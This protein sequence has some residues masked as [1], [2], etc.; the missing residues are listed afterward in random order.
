MANGM[1]LTTHQQTTMNRLLQRSLQQLHM[2]A[3]ELTHEISSVMNSNPLL[4]AVEDTNTA[5][6]H[7]AETAGE[8]PAPESDAD[9][10]PRTSAYENWGRTRRVNG[11]G[12]GDFDWLASVPTQTSL[13]GHLRE[14]LHT[15]QVDDELIV[16]G[17]AV[18]DSLDERGYL[19]DDLPELARAFGLDD[20]QAR[21]LSE[22]LDMVQHL[23]P[24]GVG[25]RN[26][27]ECL[28][29]QLDRLPGDTEHRALAA[30]IVD[31]HLDDLG[32]STL[33]TLASQ[34]ET[35]EPVLREAI[36]L[37]RTLEPRP[38]LAFDSTPVDYV[39]ADLIVFKADGRWQVRLNEAG[40]PRI[41]VN[42]HYARAIGEQ[43]DRNGGREALREKLREARWLIR[44]IEQRA[45]TIEKV[46]TAIVERQQGFFE[47]GDIGLRPMTLAEVADAV[48]VHESTV[49]RVVNN[50][51]IQSPGGLIPMRKLFGSA[52]ATSTGRSAS[53]AAVKA[54]IQS[55][56]DKE[57]PD[58]PLSDHRLTE[59]LARKGI[60][61]ARRTVSKYRHAMGVEPL[62]MRRVNAQMR[63]HEGA[64]AQ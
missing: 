35:P 27:S 8:A 16:L 59:L 60:R 40:R 18:I 45:T 36:G 23:D 3:L 5:Q 47:H 48:G 37:I 28:R 10:A 7:I 62:E 52:I 20:T 34:L 56:I 13:R 17:E 31:H 49:S 22:A 12:D 30:T 39:V 11:Q 43:R 14:Q 42:E 19:N 24:A 4:E 6:S 46:G 63:S 57:P 26:L 58:E 61:I 25:A 29:L 9:H 50:K 32:G 2:N 33:R 53:A 51:Y 44:S 54:M 21:R 15:L 1:V 41:A 64:R 38:G 55:L